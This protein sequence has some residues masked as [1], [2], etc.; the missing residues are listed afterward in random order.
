MKLLNLDWHDAF[1]LL[2]K[3]EALSVE[4]RRFLIDRSVAGYGSR[5][6]DDKLIDLGWLEP[7]RKKTVVRYRVPEPRRFW[8]KLLRIMSRATPFPDEAPAG[9]IAATLVLQDYLAQ[10]YTGDE[11]SRLGRQ[12]PHSNRYQLAGEMVRVEWWR[13]FLDWDDE[14]DSD[15][16]MGAERPV[17]YDE[18]DQDDPDRRDDRLRSL[19]AAPIETLNLSARSQHCLRMLEVGTIGDLTRKTEN[20][21]AVL[22]NVGRHTLTEI[23]NSLDEHGLHLG[24][25]GDDY[26]A[27]RRLP[28]VT[29]SGDL[30]RVTRPRGALDAHGRWQQ[31]PPTAVTT[32]QE[33]IDT[34]VAYGGPVA[35]S[36]LLKTSGD[37]SDRDDLAA[38]LDFAFREALLLIVVDAAMVPFVCI[39]PPIL[40]RMQRDSEPSPREG[41]FRSDDLV[42][43]PFLIEDISTVLLEAIAEPPRLKSGTS[44]L[45]VRNLRTIGGALPALPAWIAPEFAPLHP[46]RRLA[47]AVQF[48]ISLRL[49]TPQESSG[50][51][52]RLVVTDDGRRWLTRPAKE[53]LKQ[54]L[55]LLREDAMLRPE[56]GHGILDSWYAEDPEAVPLNFVP[57]V[58]GLGW[59][60]ASP[61]RGVVDAFRAVGRESILDLRAFILYHAEK[62]N[63]LLTLD[64]F[65][66]YDHFVGDDGR[67]DVER[68]W[69]STLLA[70]F[71]ERLL[72]LGGVALG[73]LAEGNAG[74]RMTE[75]GRYL[76]GE[77]DDFDLDTT[78]DTGDVVVQPNF[79][80]VFLSPSPIQQVR[81]RA[82]AAPTAALK[83]PESVGT[84]FVI[85]RASV[86]RAV[87]AGQDAEQVIAGAGD[88]S[89]QPLPANVTRQ[90]RDWAAEVRWIDVRPA[91]LVDCGD[92]ETAARV[93]SAV[94]KRGRLISE[95]VVEL[96]DGTDLTPA[97][98]RKLVTRGVFVRS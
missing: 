8:L 80:I 84:L 45:F 82:F 63:P 74:F 59:F 46:E 69:G 16:P 41:T 92:A 25:T 94:G 87:M 32:A 10:H 68:I 85:S 97:I 44:Q 35:I 95:G 31:A 89:K 73:P 51:N 93:L 24:M 64:T 37:S 67:E 7:V 52:R 78:E 1:D 91:V 30:E 47:R 5:I 15:A 49:A 54:I 71:H 38:G 83:S 21:I 42:D 27:A 98:R 88:L 72:P 43:R 20:E 18:P 55:D 19:L 4:Q 57:N 23:R 13:Q 50:T 81:A 28:A 48:A 79:E 60:F 3:W 33:L 29:E 9:D 6:G 61:D 40:H 22:R 26:R 56:E 66:G 65:I 36:D 12:R 96:V 11:V 58:D 90:M 14:P 17:H 39:W 53:R 2:P 77:A 75:I 70:F 62:R 34:V 86:Q 76:L